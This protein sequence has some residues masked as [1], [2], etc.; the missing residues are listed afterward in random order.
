MISKSLVAK[1][2]FMKFYDYNFSIN[3]VELK[4]NL[5]QFLSYEFFWNTI[6]VLSFS[7]VQDF[8]TDLLKNNC[9]HRKVLGLQLFIDDILGSCSFTTFSIMKSNRAYLYTNTL[10]CISFV[11]ELNHRYITT[12]NLLESK[13]C[14]VEL[15]LKQ[16]CRL[17]N[18]N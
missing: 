12:Q 15:I 10:F 5:Y 18:M 6:F 9:H 11:L 17:P 8:S 14:S 13:S 16:N 4:N 2:I 7:R 3:T 1:K